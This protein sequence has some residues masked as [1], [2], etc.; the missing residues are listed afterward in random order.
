MSKLSSRNSRIA[1]KNNTKSTGVKF[2]GTNQHNLAVQDCHERIQR[3]VAPDPNEMKCVVAATPHTSRQGTARS[4][5]KFTQA[6]RSSFV[7]SETS[8]GIRFVVVVVHFI[9]LIC[10]CDFCL[11]PNHKVSTFARFDI[12][13]LP[14]QTHLHI[15]SVRRNLKR[16]ANLI[17]EK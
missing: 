10:T 15:P 2:E 1:R 9:K 8:F 14:K 6:T 16:H 7:I 12:P 11:S 17:S 4:A 5:V 3:G 13:P